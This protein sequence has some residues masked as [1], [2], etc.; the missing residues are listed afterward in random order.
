MSFSMSFKPL[1]FEVSIHQTLWH[2]RCRCHCY[3]LLPSPSGSR[4]GE[5][6]Q[7][8]WCESV[9]QGLQKRR[10]R[11]RDFWKSVC[12]KTQAPLGLGDGQNQRLLF[13]SFS[14]LGDVHKWLCREILSWRISNKVFSNCHVAV[15]VQFHVQ[16][17]WQKLPPKFGWI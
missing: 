11:S 3:Q 9:G 15:L 6:R 17:R 1:F 5:A 8:R 14:F 2:L 16:N 10:R 4:R 13:E 12:S 7:G